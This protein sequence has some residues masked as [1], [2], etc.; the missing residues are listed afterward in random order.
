MSGGHGPPPRTCPRGAPGTIFG[1]PPAKGKIAKKRAGKSHFF[2]AGGARKMTPRGRVFCLPGPPGGPSKGGVPRF[3]IPL[4][5]PRVLFSAANCHSWYRFW[6]P[7]RSRFWPRAKRR[8]KIA[9]TGKKFGQCNFTFVLAHPAA[10]APS[11][12][13]FRARTPRARTPSSAP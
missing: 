4:K 10:A 9:Q 2:P 6:L 1:H 13:R 12:S 3:F 7:R 5:S 11:S 8:W